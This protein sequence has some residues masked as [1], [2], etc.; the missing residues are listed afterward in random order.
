M[1]TAIEN[2]IQ[3]HWPQ[4][5]G[6]VVY[7]GLDLDEYRKEYDV[8]GIRA[9]YGLAPDDFVIGTGQTHTVREFV[10]IVFEEL[11]LNYEDHL[12]IDPRF[13]RPAEVE[14]LVA[15]PAKAREKLGWKPKVNFKELALNMVRAD[16]DILMKNK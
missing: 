15:N 5:S 11:E 16:Y 13:Y 7:D 6:Q 14:I 1:S 12:I 9:Q 10:Q 8:A 3:Q 2:H 4:A